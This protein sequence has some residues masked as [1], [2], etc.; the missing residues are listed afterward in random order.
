MLA[1]EKF[2]AV[3]AM[4]AQLSATGDCFILLTPPLA[5]AIE[6]RSDDELNALGDRGISKAERNTAMR[7][8]TDLVIAVLGDQLDEFI[9]YKAPDSGEGASGEWRGRAE[10]VAQSLVDERLRRRY[11]LK[12]LSKAPAFVDIDWDIKVKIDDAAASEF[13]PFPYTTLKLR[14]QREF[15]E[16]PWF[17]LGTSP[18]ESVQVNFSRDELE[19]LI[20]SL[21]LAS[22][23]L[24]KA[25]RGLP[26][27]IDQS[28]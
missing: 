19:Y 16:G 12:R 7:E 28:G 9:E 14:F 24:N 18:L 3:L 21:K 8:I 25:E 20:H 1:R 27:D 26:H 4:I 6:V 2:D 10:A 15:G 5:A 11:L 17:F 13:K 23:A 22:E